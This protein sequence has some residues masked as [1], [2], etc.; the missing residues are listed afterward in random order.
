MSVK[1]RQGEGSVKEKGASMRM[2]CQGEGSVK[3][4]AQSRGRER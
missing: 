4:K 3:E 2:E 1:G